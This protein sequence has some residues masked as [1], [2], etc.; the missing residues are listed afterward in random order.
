MKLTMPMTYGVNAAVQ[1]QREA[2][3]L[4]GRSKAARAARSRDLEDRCMAIERAL[5]A[6]K[7]LQTP[8]KVRIRAGF[9]ALDDPRELPPSLGGLDR[10]DVIT[11]HDDWRT[12]PPMAKLIIRPTNA[13]PSYLS[14]LYVLNAEDRAMWGRRAN[15]SRMD[16]RDS[17]A[18]LCGRWVS[19]P[20]GRRA[21]MVRDLDALAAA[22]LVAIGPR[23]KQ[24]RYEGFRIL[25]ENST[26]EVY[27]SPPASAD[28]PGTLTLPGA[29]F[30]NGWHLVLTPSEIAVFLMALHAAEVIP[31]AH[32]VAI[33]RSRRWSHYGISPEAYS[34]IHELGEFG[35]LEIIDPMPNR[36][37][38]KISRPDADRRQDFEAM[39]Q[40]FGPVP[41][42]LV[43]MADD[44]FD[45]PALQTVRDRLT[46][47]DVPPRLKE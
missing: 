44:V 42:R 47:S 25:K 14:M 37:R 29:F 36:R 3:R 40:S 2:E 27:Q 46:K 22:D 9:V 23:G 11:R 33:P 21:R 43:V 30:R 4:R 24:A 19:S 16:G 34:G 10:D 38:G 18:V 20:R 7:G 15:V 17:W 28:W 6:Y 26:G 32:S 8:S 12:R 5:D 41:Y 31:S 45:R 1:R 35:L 39:G 13:L